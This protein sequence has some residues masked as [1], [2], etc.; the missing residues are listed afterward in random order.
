MNR[1]YLQSLPYHSAGIHYGDEIQ[2]IS[3]KG[4]S[5]LNTEILLISEVLK[6]V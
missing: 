5:A 2:D 6:A 1:L 3:A 4:L